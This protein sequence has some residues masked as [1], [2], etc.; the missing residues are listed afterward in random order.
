MSSR[1]TFLQSE[2]QQ[3]QDQIDFWDDLAPR[4]DAWRKRGSAYHQ[5]IIRLF[6]FLVPPGR[7][8]LEIGSTTGDLLAALEP[9]SGTGVDLSPRMVETASAK[10]PH[11]RFF[12]GDAEDLPALLAEEEYDFVLMSDLVGHLSDIWKAFRS[13]RALASPHTRLVI[14]WYNFLWE[15]LLKFGERIGLKMPVKDEN[16]LSFADLRGLLHLNHFD[17]VVQGSRTLVP[18]RV[19]LLAPLANHV[20]AP[21]PGIR[22]LNLIQYL[23]ARPSPQPE[24]APLS[25]SVIIP[26][27]NEKGNI[28]NALERLP[29][30]GPEMEVVF[31]D[32]HSSDGTV[33]EIEALEGEGWPFRIRLLHQDGKGK[34]DAVRKAF[35]EA[36]NDVLFIL[37]ADLT[38]APEDLP[39]FYL[40]IAE[41][42]AELVNGTRLVYPMEKE[43]MRTLNML[44]NKAFSLL[45]SWILGQRIKDTLC[46]TKV[47]K[48]SHHIHIREDYT[49]FG[50]FDP[51]GDFELILGAAKQNLQICDLPVRYRAR[52]SGDTKMDRFRSGWILFRMALQGFRKLRLRR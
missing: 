33:E 40:A 50:D 28:R 2:R 6:R 34:G 42:R 47:V 26:C 18:A 27:R 37:D 44:G 38:V 1:E 21:L 9:S 4:R 15:P 48:R 25:T 13:V 32:G 46:G 5:E 16:W 35:R 29:K 3:K 23:V 19:P 30:M 36:R 22:Q 49:Y 39:K 45:F 20:L 7:R 51:W 24:P 12:Q 43:A 8:V 31:C 14:S 17:V 11:L 41:G 52:V 10:Y